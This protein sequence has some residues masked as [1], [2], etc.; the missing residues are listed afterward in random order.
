MSSPWVA[1]SSNI[2]FNTGSVGIGSSAPAYKLD[3]SG[4][5]AVNGTTVVGGNVGVKIWQVIAT[6]SSSQGT[7]RSVNYPSGLVNANII[8]MYGV[9]ISAVGG[10]NW[11]HLM[12]GCSRDPNWYW[13]MWTDNNSSSFTIWTGTSA[14]AVLGA[15]VSCVF[16]TN[17]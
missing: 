6:L 14:G 11:Q 12:A 2:Y 8:G 15:T 10:A 1:S 9:T 16:I 7:A 3:V 5:V 4:N 17:G 13:D